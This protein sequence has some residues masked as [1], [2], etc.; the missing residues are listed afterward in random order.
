MKKLFLILLFCTTLHAQEGMWPINMLPKPIDLDITKA[1]KSCLRLSSGGSASFVSAH[2]LVMTNHHV[3][4]KAIYSLSSEENDLIKNGF[5]AKTMAEERICPDLYADQLISIQDVTDEVNKTSTSSMTAKERELARQAQIAKITKK[6]QDET[7][8]QP[9]MV[10]LYRGARYHLYL[11]KRYTD[12]RLVMAPEMGIAFFGGDKENFEFPRHNLDVC[13]FR[14]YENGKPLASEN[15]FCWSKAGAKLAEKI[16]VLGHPGRTERMLTRAHLAYM[17][18]HTYPYALGYIDSRIATLTQYS[19]KSAEHARIAASELFSLQNS[20]K[21]LSQTLQ[22]LDLE[23]VKPLLGLE[24]AL[25]TLKQFHREFYHI[26]VV[27]NNFSRYF[28][29]AKKLVR[30][31]QER[32][33][34][35]EERLHEYRSHELAALELDL[36]SDTPLYP[37][38]EK[39][40][41]QASI[42]T[43]IALFGNNHPVSKILSAVQIDELFSTT[44]L[45]SVDFRKKQYQQLTDDPFITL[46]KALDP[47]M[48]ALRDRYEHEFQSLEKECYAKIADTNSYPDATFT[49]RLSVGEMMGYENIPAYTTFGSLFTHPEAG[50]L[51]KSWLESEQKLDKSLPFNFISTNDII[52]GNSGSPV[53]NKELEIV[54]LIFDGNHDSCSWDFAYDATRGRAISVHS[55][56]II[57]ALKQV[58]HADE[59]VKELTAG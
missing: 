2:G 33:K 35:N 45:G 43:F 15:H 1:Q 48:R 36:F 58:Y 47:Y 9:Q 22:T 18:D 59:L 50:E 27:S 30:A 57:E 13:F 14:I 56:A 55:Q 24:E 28:G 39:V 8:L 51:P 6:A 49:L 29:W 46:A 23:N 3:G 34:P 31:H 40:K 20:K 4:S 41:F 16:Y 52:G 26:E 11:Y 25:D 32:L 7:G 54:G 5:Y 44:Q 17:K 37:D 53:L 19:Q 12:V 21:V 42:D 10:M 38:F